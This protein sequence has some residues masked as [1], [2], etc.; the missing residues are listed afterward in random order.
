MGAPVAPATVPS[1][2]RPE[3][4][5]ARAAHC[6]HTHTH[7]H[8]PTPTHNT[9]TRCRTRSHKHVLAA[10]TP[11]SLFRALTNQPSLPCKHAHAMVLYLSMLPQAEFLHNWPWSMKNGCFSVH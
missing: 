3:A 4:K 6:T 8:T 10:H 5:H 1:G 7:T 11:R 9:L 2:T